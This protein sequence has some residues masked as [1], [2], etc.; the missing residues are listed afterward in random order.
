MSK[1]IPLNIL[2]LV[3]KIQQNE[4]GQKN[5]IHGLYDIHFVQDKKQKQIKNMIHLGNYTKDWWDKYGFIWKVP[6]PIHLV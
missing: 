4:A 5:G 3:S 6:P 2:S 1:W